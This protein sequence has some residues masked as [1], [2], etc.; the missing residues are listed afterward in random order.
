VSLQI[1]DRRVSAS[2]YSLTVTDNRIEGSLSGIDLHRK[3]VQVAVDL[4]GF[5]V[6]SDPYLCFITQN[7]PPKLKARPSYVGLYRAEVRFNGDSFDK[8]VGIN[9][10]K[11]DSVASGGDCNMTLRR[12]G[13]VMHSWNHE[14]DKPCG[15][16]REDGT[17]TITIQGD[18]ESETW[19][20]RVEALGQV[21]GR[22]TG[23]HAFSE[24][25]KSGRPIGKKSVP[26]T[27]EFRPRK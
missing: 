17:F 5:T 24:F 23:T 11:P 1:D 18:G 27:G 22:I 8:P 9:T 12:D 26:F 16:W 4:G 21:R 15:E 6:A 25:D 2:S 13:K 7:K 14:S 3:R 20:G 10:R 19:T